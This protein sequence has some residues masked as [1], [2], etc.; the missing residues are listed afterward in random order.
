MSSID[1][2]EHGLHIAS[3]R[4]VQANE[5]GEYDRVISVCQDTCR[6][7]V[8][9]ATP[10]EH[11]PLADD[12]ESR[13]HWGGSYEYEDFAAAAESVL[14]S[15]QADADEQVLVHCHVGKNRSAAVCAAALAVH[16][17]RTFED[18]LAVVE[19]TRPKVD[20]NYLMQAHGK[21]F[22]AEQS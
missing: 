5:T 13:H 1:H 3:I 10:Y 14:S 9:E 18:A 20:P 12:P 22:V 16:T 4:A 19:D 8:S 2:I 15:L 21:Q 6:Q 7:N 11:Y 17:D